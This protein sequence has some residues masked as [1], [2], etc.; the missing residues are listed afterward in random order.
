MCVCTLALS[1]ER[2][3][4]RWAHISKHSPRV[5]SRTAPR[6]C[7]KYHS[8]SK[9]TRIPYR[10]GNCKVAAEKVQDEPRTSC[11]T[12]NQRNAWRMNNKAVSKGHGSQL[13]GANSV[14]TEDQHKSSIQDSGTE[15]PPPPESIIHLHKRGPDCILGTAV[16]CIVFCMTSSAARDSAPVVVA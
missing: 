4:E 2:A 15:S 9:K 10:N 5:M 8:T 16:I 3:G 14:T 12:R 13:E 1:T 7:F 6:P 11:W